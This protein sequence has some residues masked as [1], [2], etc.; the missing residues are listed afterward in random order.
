MRDPGATV[1]T[2]PTPALGLTRAYQRRPDVEA[3]IRALPDPTDPQ[4][5]RAAASAQAPHPVV[6]ATPRLRRPG[7][8]EGGVWGQGGGRGRSM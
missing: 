1:V 8:R 6:D 3:E 5:R 2:P 4:F 7:G